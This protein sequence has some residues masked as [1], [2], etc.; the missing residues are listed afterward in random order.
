MKIEAQCAIALRPVIPANA[1]TNVSVFRF[2]KKFNTR[3][4][5]EVP[6]GFYFGKH[7]TAGSIE[8]SL[9]QTRQ[10]EQDSIVFGLQ[11]VA[12]SAQ[13]FRLDFD[14]HLYS[15]EYEIVRLVFFFFES[16]FVSFLGSWP[17]VSEI[18]SW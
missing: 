1:V 6:H 4:F 10:H 9:V 12:M 18:L 5:I 15:L 7:H 2:V 16:K 3:C 17:F 11:T 14:A 8:F 13:I